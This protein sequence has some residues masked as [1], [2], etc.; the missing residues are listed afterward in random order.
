[1]GPHDSGIRAPALRHVEVAERVADAGHA[2]IGGMRDPFANIGAHR[3]VFGMLIGALALL[4]FA[5]L[6]PFIVPIAWATIM[7]FTTWP[8]Y[9]SLRRMLGGRAML[10]AALMTLLLSAAL[11]LPLLW[12]L[13]TL[14]VELASAYQALS[15][16][17]A[18]GPRRVPAAIAALPG[19]GEWLQRWLD[20]L[21]RAPGALQQQIREWFEQGGG[22]LL[23]LL[24]GAGRNAV[25]LGVALLT[26]LFLYRDGEAMLAQ[27]RE[28]LRRLV[29]SRIDGYLV[30]TGATTR[31]VVYGIF[32]AALGQ[33]ALATLGYWASGVEAPLLLGVLTAMVAMLPLGA[34]IVWVPAGLWLL[35]SG[36]TGAGIGLLL[37]GALAVSWVDNLLRPL[38]ISS[39]SR[40]PFL[41]VMFGVLGGAASFG[42]IGLFVGPVIL[43][44]VMAIWREWLG[45]GAPPGVDRGDPADAGDSL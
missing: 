13:A 36:H 29:G 34:S 23:N 1:M 27:L 40:T 24:G 15:D 20:D 6:Q 9:S 17:L 14:Q 33:G 16:W 8:M 35:M 4:A 43:A 44:I 3:I 30:A 31:G 26:A 37:W 28:G 5:V 21:T 2:T 41:L 18:Q 38:V 42:L 32:I 22:G 39:A 12:L 10:A 11:V 25:K 7:V 19:I 45:K